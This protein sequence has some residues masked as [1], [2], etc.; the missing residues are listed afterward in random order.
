MTIGRGRKVGTLAV[1]VLAQLLIAI[2]LTVLHLVLP[3]LSEQ[4]R[5]SATEML[6]IADAYG[7]ALA[8]LLITM[9]NVGDRIG[10]KKLL[11]IGA[12]LFG[13]ASVITAYAPTAELLIAARVLLGIA[14]AT[15]MPS[16]L[17][18]VRNVFTGKERAAAIG[19][20]SGLTILGFGLGPLVG[21]VLLEHFWW[22]SVF[23]VN[24]PVVVVMVI[25]GALILPESKNPE[26]GRIDVLSVLLSIVGLVGIV[27]TIKEI[28]YKGWGHWDIAVAAVLGLGTLPAFFVRQPRLAEPLMDLKLFTQRAFSATIGTTILAMFAQLAVSVMF[29]QYLQLVAGWSPLKSGLAGLPGM[30]GAILGGVLAPLGIKLFG[31]AVTIALGCGLSAVGFALYSGISVTI[32]Y[33]ELLAA[34]IIFGVGLALILSVATD[35]V[36]GVVPKARAGAASAISETATELGGALGIAVLGSVL[37]ALYRSELVVPAGLPSETVSDTLGGAVQ[38]AAQLPP[39]QGALV[40]ANA[41]L[42]FV[43]GLQLTMLC[44]AGLMALL[45][46]SAL[47]TLRGVPKVLEDPDDTSAF[48]PLNAEAPHASHRV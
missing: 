18:I 44:S 43:D 35:T 28:A 42:A 22:G 37:G 19:I 41:K 24:V 6:W 13:I 31:R 46:A 16:T 9:G 17:S 3:S 25:A 27:Y 38:V 12:S 21:G 20:S 30:G 14:A 2:D 39:E 10:R 4:L 23:L 15:L 48:G 40:L 33:P 5:P 47:F 1:C 7:F 29:A 34:M 8:G 45:A 11:L 26:P 36:L 32:V